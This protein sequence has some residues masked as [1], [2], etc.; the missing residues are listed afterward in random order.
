MRKTWVKLDG[1]K[2]P[3]E[4]I[5]SS[6]SKRATALTCKDFLIIK[7]DDLELRVQVFI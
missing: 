3:Y 6:L 2:K 1:G 4:H 5:L 7:F